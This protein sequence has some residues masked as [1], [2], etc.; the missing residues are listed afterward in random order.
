MRWIQ[1]TVRTNKVASIQFIR[2]VD[3]ASSTG[4]PGMVICPYFLLPWGSR[5]RIVDRDYLAHCGAASSSDPVALPPPFVR[6]LQH[7][8]TEQQR[9]VL[10][11]NLE[12][13]RRLAHLPIFHADAGQ[14]N[15]QDEDLKRKPMV[16]HEVGGERSLGGRQHGG[17][18]PF[19][20]VSPGT[21]LPLHVLAPPLVPLTRTSSL[22]KQTRKRPNRPEHTHE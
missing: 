4:K 20:R 7:A 16:S 22:H 14:T 21:P 6:G 12:E 10:Q 15:N 9:C 19:L 8:H 11:L 5:P 18:S 17:G 3:S 1:C 13:R 2:I